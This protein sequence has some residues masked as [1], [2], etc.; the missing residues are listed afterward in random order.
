MQ[1]LDGSRVGCGANLRRASKTGKEAAM[2]RTGIWA[3]IF[4]L[5]LSLTA[6]LPAA[7]DAST[8]PVIALI[9]RHA[10][11][12]P[13][14]C[15]CTYVGA[16]TF[17]VRQPAPDTLVVT[18]LGAVVATS[19]PAGSLAVMDFEFDQAF[20]VT[21]AMSVKPQLSLESELIGV[22]RGGKIAAAETSA[23]ATVAAGESVIVAANLPDRA[24][25]CGENRT[26]NDRTAPDDVPIAPGAFTLHA[27]WHLAATHPKGLRGKAASAEFAPEP[28]L[29]PIWV[30]GPRDPFHGIVK[31]DF[32]LRI[33]LKVLPQPPAPAVRP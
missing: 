6:A 12:V 26:V 20:E 3:A 7:G 25:S 13:V 21:C 10:D 19:H 31:K 27:H 17:D 16:G 18:M 15:G 2:V 22:L 29:D 9:D 8:K 30:G 5:P 4:G 14:R 33:T 24:V 1:S 32:G 23:G 11:A 28:A